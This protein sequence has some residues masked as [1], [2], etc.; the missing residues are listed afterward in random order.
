M[1]AFQ[2]VYGA[3]SE[4]AALDAIPSCQPLPCEHFETAFQVCTHSQ[5]NIYIYNYTFATHIT[6]CNYIRLQ[7]RCV[8]HAVVLEELHFPEAVSQEHML[9]VP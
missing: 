2:G 3:Y 1:V 8:M 7:D 4:A 5:Y 9:E 6:A